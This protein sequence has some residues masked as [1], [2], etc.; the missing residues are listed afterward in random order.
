[1]AS[2]VAVQCHGANQALDMCVCCL[3]I[4]RQCPTFNN[5]YWVRRESKYILFANSRPCQHNS[6]YT[7][8][9]TIYYLPVTSEDDDAA[10]AN[11]L[12]AIRLYT[13]RGLPGMELKQIDVVLSYL[14]R[15]T[16][17]PQRLLWR[18]DTVCF[19]PPA[20]VSII[21]NDDDCLKKKKKHTHTIDRCISNTL[22]SFQAGIRCQR[23]FFFMSISLIFTAI[24]CILYK[25]HLRLCNSDELLRCCNSRWLRGYNVDFVFLE[26]T[27]L[28]ASSTV[29]VSF[30]SKRNQWYF[31]ILCKKFCVCENLP[32]LEIL[33]ATFVF[34]EKSFIYSTRLQINHIQ[35]NAAFFIKILFLFLDT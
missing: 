25:W 24:T 30:Q 35:T 34:F 17:H 22:L 6:A 5:C 19:Y 7:N 16:L 14:V 15:K 31:K 8:M 26:K 1:M 11:A 23:I 9:R 33:Y 4:D 10:S 2:S 32:F 3:R 12:H 13:V 27:R 18:C 28:L 29:F 21:N 20:I